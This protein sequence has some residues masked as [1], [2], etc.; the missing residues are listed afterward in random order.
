MLTEDIRKFFHYKLIELGDA[1]IKIEYLKMRKDGELKDEF[2]HLET[3]AFTHLINL[4]K[5][6]K[7][8]WI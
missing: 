8:E 1:N 4:S 6:F 5:F 2:K 7:E 3:E